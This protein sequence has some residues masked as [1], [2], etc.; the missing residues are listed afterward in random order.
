MAELSNCKQRA[1]L[2]FIDP[3]ADAPR[4]RGAYCR[5]STEPTRDDYRHAIRPDGDRIDQSKVRNEVKIAMMASAASEDIERLA[6]IGKVGGLPALAAVARA[7]I[8]D[9]ILVVASRNQ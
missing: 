7:A 8:R 4:T 6:R 3:M 1:I 2:A 9:G 5:R